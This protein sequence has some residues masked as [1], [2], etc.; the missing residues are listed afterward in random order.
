[1]HLALRAV[2]VFRCF[3]Q[4]FCR[5]GTSVSFR[6]VDAMDSSLTASQVRQKFIE[7]FTK[8]KGKEHTFVHSS[9]VIPHDDPTLLFANAGMNQYKP[10][11]LGTV[12]PNSDMAKWT[13]AVNSQKCI[14]AGGK[15]NDLDDVGK[16]VYHHTFFEMLG[17]WSF[18][19]YFKKGAIEFAWD[20]LTN[21]FKLP[22]DRLY[23]TYFGGLKEAGLDV[24]EDARQIWL[25]MGIPEDRVLPFGMRDNF[26]EMGEV[27]PCG[28]CTEIHFDRIGGRNVA[29][30]V[31]E[32]DPDVLEIW[33]LVFIQFNREADG[34]LKKLPKQHV[35]T[36]MGLERI[37]SVIQ[38]KQS[39]Y[40]TDLFTPLFAAIQKATG[41]RPYQ[42]KVGAADTDGIDMAYRV[43]ADHARTLTVA[44]ADGGRPDSTGRGYVLRRILRRAV[45]FSSEK[46]NGRPGMFASLVNV[47]V[48]N[49]GSAFPEIT[50]DPQEIMDIINEE[51]EQ[52]LKTLARGKRLFERTVTKLTDNVVP[53]DVAWRLYDTYGFPLDL[54]QLMSEERNLTVNMDEYEAAKS[55]AQV[56]ARGKGSGV[57]DA[58]NL[59]VHAI[60]EL[61]DKGVALTDDSY[62]YGYKADENGEYNFEPIIS[63]VKA[64]RL[65]QQFVDEVT[66]GMQCGI[67]LDKTCCY[68]EQG[69]Q[70][71]D[72]GFMVKVGD[73]ETEFSLIDVQVRGGYVLHVGSVEGT[74]RI[75]D[76]LKVLI[77]ESRRRLIMSNHTAT[78]LLNF[79]L[80]N[81]LG[82]ADQKGSLVAPDRLRFD[83][84]A[85]SPMTTEQMKNSENIVG[86]FVSKDSVVYAREAPLPVAKEIQGLRAI[87]E[88]A[89]PD[90][91][92]ILSVGIPV[93]DLVSDPSQ[94]AGSK[95][96]VEFCGGTHV[97]KTGHIGPFAII[98]EEALAKGIRR[99]VALTG[100][101]A[102]HSHRRCDMLQKSVNDLEVEVKKQSAEGGESDQSLKR[103]VHLNEEVMSAV[104]SVWRKDAMRES[105]QSLKKL[106]LE[107]EKASKKLVMKKATDKAKELLE[108]N[109]DKPFVV[110]VIDVGSVGKAL[111]E[112]M[113][114]FKKASPN[115]ALLLF[116]VDK[117][118]GKIIYQCQVPKSAAQSGLKADSWVKS[119][120]DLLEG[121]VGGKDLAAQG[122]GSN[123]Y[124]LDEALTLARQFAVMKLHEQ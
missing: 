43:L 28:P 98:S 101:A 97:L 93:E 31:N 41:S 74:I 114:Q 95:T 61:R 87:F 18:G 57:D 46:L 85:K 58:V 12:D 122:S 84:T 90:P 69:G 44:L 30:L 117:N 109:K 94:P 6:K 116:S 119:F 65:N 111:S 22:K 55:R 112:A 86:D 35:D 110:E 68:A 99:I 123:I 27:G 4:R 19:D 70:A 60:S 108:V 10:I 47:V 120:S 89:Y 11:F 103:V 26:W 66:S 40:D 21:V 107:G 67:I 106:L 118:E 52:F 2:G 17:N 5:L 49:L 75:G 121:K 92:R 51:E 13:C 64:L 124:A 79:A 15:H 91:V 100:Q 113:Q 24:D 56:I 104:V 102:N 82:E 62:K 63:Q 73:E 1:M 39:N 88:E 14:R 77:D 105:L 37:A 8:K 81:Q 3:H 96:S 71:Y 9:S 34:S 7:Y 54:T 59:D 53:G 115:T 83:F 20:L 42:G 29:H 36:G 50:K 80:R 45:R 32:D 33:N 23:V 25:S 72:L 48:E 78:H 38:G 76:K 16:D